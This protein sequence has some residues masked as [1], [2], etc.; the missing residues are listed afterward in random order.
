[1]WSTLQNKLLQL[2]FRKKYF[3]NY[4]FF[5]LQI[6]IWEVWSFWNSFSSNSNFGNFDFWNCQHHGEWSNCDYD[7]GSVCRSI[8]AHIMWDITLWC[9]HVSHMVRSNDDAICHFSLFVN[10][11][12]SCEHLSF[13]NQWSHGE[14][15]DYSSSSSCLSFFFSISFK[16]SLYHCLRRPTSLCQKVFLSFTPSPQP[17]SW[18]SIALSLNPIYI[19]VNFSTEIQIIITIFLLKNSFINS[20]TWS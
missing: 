16:L 9:D 15:Q 1:M 20:P 4:S 11:S 3:C 10:L 6:F 12:V 7:R 17:S 19:C 2:I 5:L 8:M 13:A 18:K 14:T